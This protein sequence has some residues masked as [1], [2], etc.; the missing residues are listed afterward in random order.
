MIHV[1][2]DTPLKEI[3]NGRGDG[4]KKVCLLVRLMRG[5]K[6][7]SELV[8]DNMVQPVISTPFMVRIH[9]P[10]LNLS[11]IRRSERDESSVYGLPCP[12]CAKICAAGG[13]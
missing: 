3:T 9:V 6:L 1:Y 7:H 8:A 4:V 11:G 12:A 10:D 13:I 5:F 2:V